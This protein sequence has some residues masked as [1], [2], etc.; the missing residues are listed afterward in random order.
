MISA[1]LVRELI[2][3]TSGCYVSLITLGRG[4]DGLGSNAP[5]PES[6]VRAAPTAEKTRRAA[7]DRILKAKNAEAKV[8]G[9]SDGKRQLALELAA[10]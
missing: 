2:A 4:S 7:T 9:T 6:D 10:T 1:S 8:V 5:W 3:T